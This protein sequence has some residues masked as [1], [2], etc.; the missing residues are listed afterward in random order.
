MRRLP[1]IPARRMSTLED[2]RLILTM[3]GCPCAEVVY[4]MAMCNAF[5]PRTPLWFQ[6]FVCVASWIQPQPRFNR[7]KT[8][9]T[10]NR[11]PPETLFLPKPTFS[12]ATAITVSL[13]NPIQIVF[14]LILDFLIQQS[15]IISEKKSF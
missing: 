4:N 6:A 7:S 9:K 12:L 3:T 11:I 2:T 14:L 8:S 10:T 15:K 5:P 13:S 1:R